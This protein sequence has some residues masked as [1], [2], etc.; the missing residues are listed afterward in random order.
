MLHSERKEPGI[1]VQI[2]GKGGTFKLRQEKELDWMW[3]DGVQVNT[4]KFWPQPMP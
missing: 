2:R 3:K 1:S 4:Q